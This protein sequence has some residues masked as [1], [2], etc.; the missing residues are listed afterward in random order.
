MAALVGERALRG[1]TMFRHQSQMT[2]ALF[3]GVASGALIASAT[4]VSAGGFEVREQSAYFQGMSFAGSAAG[5]SSLSSIFWNP[6]TSSFVADG[7]T[8]NSNYSLILPRSDVRI[9]EAEVAPGVT[10]PCG[11]G[12]LAGDCE[13]DVADDAIVPASYAAYR[14]D[15]KT[16]FALAFNSQFGLGTSPDNQNWV[17]AP[18]ASHASKLFSI[19]A[20]PSVSYEIM[21]GLSVGAGVQIQYFDLKRL[22]SFGAIDPDG[23]GPS[24]TLTGTTNLKGDD[25]GVGWTIGVNF[26]PVPGTSIGI[27]YRSAIDH[28]L[29]GKIGATNGLSLLPIFPA[30][31]TADVETPDKVTGSIRQELSPTMRLMATVE[32]T[33]WSKLGTIPVKGAP[34]PTFLE[35]EWEDGWLFALGG[36]FDYNEKLTLRLGGAYEISPIQD[37]T[38]RLVQLPDA[39]RIW[40][41]IGGSYKLGNIFGMGDTTADFAYSH[42]FVEDSNF[43]RH[44]ASAA[45]PIYSGTAESAVDIITVGMTTKW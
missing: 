44:P 7:F 17:G 41:S 43:E 10:L 42:V 36:E 16:V 6:A 31:I 20:V 29:E 14:Y 13:V 9:R 24:P 3:L 19:N 45:F 12:P 38:S 39:D 27:G 11:A 25:I 32:W 23:P 33:N 8:T 5:G 28:D 37:A 1:Y 35:F 18:L 2:K 30:S 34:S 22:K 40:A 26:E 4:A 21:P 15:S